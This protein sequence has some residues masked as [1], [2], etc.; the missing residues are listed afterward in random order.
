MDFQA[1]P[2]A[3]TYAIALA[4]EYIQKNILTRPIER[5][6][7]Y[8]NAIMYGDRYLKTAIRWGNRSEA[9]DDSTY[10]DIVIL[11]NETTGESTSGIDVDIERAEVPPSGSNVLRHDG[12]VRLAEPEAWTV[13]D[14]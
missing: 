13:I 12:P 10:R 5:I 14:S 6:A 8:R 2:N 4:V 9:H 1:W 11:D 7:I 3:R